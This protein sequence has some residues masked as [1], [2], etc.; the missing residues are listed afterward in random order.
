MARAL[1]ANKF[2]WTKSEPLRQNVLWQAALR[3]ALIKKR[4][5]WPPW[6]RFE[7]MTPIL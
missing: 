5:S 4:L 7:S 1:I 2:S 6:R 3:S